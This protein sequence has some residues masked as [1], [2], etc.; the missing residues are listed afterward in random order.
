MNYSTRFSFLISRAS[1]FSSPASHF[2]KRWQ[3]AINIYGRQETIIYHPL[4][5]KA[6]EI[7]NYCWTGVWKETKDTTGIRLLKV[8][9]LSVRSFLDRDLQTRSMSLTYSTVLSI[10]PA[11]ALL[12][13]IGRGFGFQKLL[14]DQ[15]MTSF[16]TRNK[17]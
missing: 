4:I 16:P 6:S 17:A 7:A 9:N 3:T 5:N 14:E 10:V 13:A 12:F 15:L 8:A 2:S 1:S 11:F